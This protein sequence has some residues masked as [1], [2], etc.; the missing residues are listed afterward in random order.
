MSSLAPTH[1][2]STDGT[3][4]GS[5][6]SR[7]G[8]DVNAIVRACK[9][10]GR[11]RAVFQPIVDLR[12]GAKC[13]FEALAR[14]PMY[15]P[16]E[17]FRAAAESEMSGWFETTVLRTALRSLPELPEGF[18]MSVNMSPD[19]IQSAEARAAF[20]DV[21][22]LEQVIIEI[23]GRVDAD[24][25]SAVADALQPAR[26]R[27]ARV[28]VDESGRSG[29]CLI[30]LT[31]LEPNFLKLERSL[32]AGIDEV[33]GLEKA[34]AAAVALAGHVGA[35]VVAQGIETEGELETIVG[36]GVPYGQGFAFG[37]PLPRLMAH[38]H[39]HEQMI[40]RLSDA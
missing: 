29:T 19:A 28:A 10:E 21:E 34:V 6:Q 30:S 13:G 22:S 18:F 32:V 5:G 20:A 31:A 2:P 8:P 37:H 39:R 9:E 36:L 27:G 15:R 1:V 23:T 4:D 16:D 3:A 12:T 11:V 33:P 40:K 24:D 38:A 35:D 7:L 25:A 26:S 17:W 14:F